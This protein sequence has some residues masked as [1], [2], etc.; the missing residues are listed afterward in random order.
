[1]RKLIINDGDPLPVGA[2]IF[3][4][5]IRRQSLQRSDRRRQRQP[6]FQRQN[7][8]DTVLAILRFS[9]WKALFI[10]F[11]LHFWH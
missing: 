11:L 3:R 5:T 2:I 1:V 10:R 7:H 6:P 4:A 8:R 9:A